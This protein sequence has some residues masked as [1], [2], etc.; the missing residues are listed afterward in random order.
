MLLWTGGQKL[1]KLTK[2]E[3]ACWD[4]LK[5]PPPDNTD[6]IMQGVTWMDSSKPK[7]HHPI[8]GSA[9]FD[10]DN[11]EAYIFDGNHWQKMIGPG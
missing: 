5:T 7:P 10:V 4:I 9:W 11:N 3:Q 8:N 2:T 6:K 1:S